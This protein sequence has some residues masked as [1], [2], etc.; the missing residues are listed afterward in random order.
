MSAAITEAIARIREATDHLADMHSRDKSCR[1][2]GAEAN[3][4]GCLSCMAQWEL[5]E[6]LLVLRS[7]SE[8]GAEGE[9]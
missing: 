7:A 6:A 1:F 5:A 2:M 4:V 9:K 3:D 8:A